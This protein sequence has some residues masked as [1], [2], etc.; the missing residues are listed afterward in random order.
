M[1]F[2]V[3]HYPTLL[4]TNDE[5]LSRISLG[6]AGEGD[7][8]CTD[9]QE[10][11]RGQAGN[12]WL[13]EPSRNLLG[14]LILKP[15]HVP[16]S[17]QFVLT[18]VISLAI[19]ESIKSLTNNQEVHIKWPNDILLNRKKVAGILFQN[20]I[21]GSFID[22]S[23]VGIGVNINQKAIGS[24]LPQACSVID[25]LDE[26][27]SVSDFRDRLFLSIEKY[28]SM[29]FSETGLKDLKKAYLNCLFQLGMPAGYEI[30]N[31]N[32]IATIVGIDLYGRL[33]VQSAD[34][35]VKAFA[36]KEIA[37]KW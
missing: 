32:V 19:A 31:E 4:S 21:K 6:V 12:S 20:S 1:K 26:E 13:S 23:V 34:G 18:Q 10:K 5:A 35:E 11:G 24:L 27:I 28:Y 25:F 2:T 16:P 3:I 17:S 33:L 14:S 22:Y 7:F 36:F 15:V 8:I 9:F 30:D 29:T 37:Y